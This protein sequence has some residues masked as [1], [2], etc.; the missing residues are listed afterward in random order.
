[1]EQSQKQKALL[2]SLTAF[3]FL[4]VF[5][6]FLPFKAGAIDIAENQKKSF[7]IQVIEKIS[8]I[9]KQT[10]YFSNQKPVVQEPPGTKQEMI[11]KVIFP[12]VFGR[13]GEVGL[14]TFDKIKK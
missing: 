1:M 6:V 2:I 3:L 13:G 11:K 8:Q 14:D 9:A 10:G 5:F 7:T 12:F 4:V